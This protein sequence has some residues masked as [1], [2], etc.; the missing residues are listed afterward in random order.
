MLGRRQFERLFF[1]LSY[2]ICDRGE[3]TRLSGL[4]PLRLAQR[5]LQARQ[6]H[7]ELENPFS[8]LRDMYLGRMIPHLQPA[9][10]YTAEIGK[11]IRNWRLWCVAFSKSV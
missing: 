9:K 11:I 10:G 4:A 2:P 6:G 5:S 3:N 7:M 1:E 8:G